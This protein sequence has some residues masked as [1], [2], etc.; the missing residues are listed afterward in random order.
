MKPTLYIEPKTIPKIISFRNFHVNYCCRNSFFGIRTSIH[1]INNPLS[2]FDI[3]WISIAPIYTTMDISFQ[4]KDE[5]S[6]TCPISSMTE[7]SCIEPSRVIWMG[8]IGDKQWLPCKRT[9]HWIC[10]SQSSFSCSI[11][12]EQPMVDSNKWKF[13]KDT[14]A[15]R[16][17][18][19]VES[20]DD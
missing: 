20:Q 10:S 3:N 18:R 16:I 1:L 8:N 6:C 11:V 7:F 13:R 12:I 19:I 17:K 14:T 15:K 4:S 5:I 2:S 9:L